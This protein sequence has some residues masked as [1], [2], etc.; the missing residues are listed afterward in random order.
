MNVSRKLSDLHPTLQPIAGRFLD[1]CHAAGIDVIVTC[2]YRSDAEQALVYAKG[3]TAPGKIVTYAKPGESRHNRTLNRK[4][5][6]EAFDVV[7]L[8]AGKPVWDASDPVWQRMGAIGEALGLEWAG[9]WKR[10]RE[11]PHFQKKIEP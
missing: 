8:E 6:S 11:F 3:R 7:A 2:T 10:N 1:E 5:A 9:R 4:P